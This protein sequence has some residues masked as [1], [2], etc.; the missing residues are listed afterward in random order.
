MPLES[1]NVGNYLDEKPKEAVLRALRALVAPLQDTWGF[2]GRFQEKA[3]PEIL[4]LSAPYLDEMEA[5]QAAQKVLMV[6]KSLRGLHFRFVFDP[7]GLQQLSKKLEPGAHTA[8]QQ[9]CL[10]LAIR[11]QQTAILYLASQEGKMVYEK[12]LGELEKQKGSLSALLGQAGQNS[13]EKVDGRLTEIAMGLWKGG[14]SRFFPAVLAEYL[15]E[16][17]RR[18]ARRVPSVHSSIG[19]EM[20]SSPLEKRVFALLEETV[21]QA[22]LFDAK[23]HF[24]TCS[25]PRKQEIY[26][27]L[28]HSLA[29]SITTLAPTA[30]LGFEPFCQGVEALAFPYPARIEWGRPLLKSLYNTS[31]EALTFSD[32][33]T[34]NSVNQRFQKLAMEKTVNPL[35]LALSREFALAA[36]AGFS[37]DKLDVA[38]VE[39][40]G[41]DLVGEFGWPASLEDLLIRLQG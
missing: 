8:F 4:R 16:R 28:R 37:A 35:A 26:T 21:T 30:P 13:V 40:T 14:K 36:L 32:C 5:A 7:A 38:E 6:V 23:H 2:P 41:L 33:P 29:R 9:G 3:I 15:L 19:D 31:R 22:E 39:L 34:P 20:D 27:T 10:W 18:A 24:S 25:D 12:L 1:Q 11:L 17:V